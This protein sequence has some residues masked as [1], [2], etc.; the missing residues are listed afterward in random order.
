M[1]Y[2]CACGTEFELTPR[3]IGQVNRGNV[4]Q[5]SDKCRQIRKRLREKKYY[6]KLKQRKYSQKHRDKVK[7]IK[8]IQHENQTKRMNQSKQDTAIN[9]AKYY[10]CMTEAAINN[11]PLRC[12][13]CENPRYKKGAWLKTHHTQKSNHDSFDE[14]EISKVEL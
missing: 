7:R 2:T 14:C 6:D 1:K 8:A 3:Q 10:K 9:C 5:C 11:Q 4:P 12:D 13:Q